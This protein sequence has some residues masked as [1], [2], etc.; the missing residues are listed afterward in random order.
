MAWFFTGRERA[1]VLCPNGLCGHVGRG[2]PPGAEGRAHVCRKCRQALP[3][4]SRNGAEPVV[5]MVV[6]THWCGK[7]SWLVRGIGRLSEGPYELEFP[8]EGQ[9][10]AWRALKGGLDCGRPVPATPAVPGAAWCIDFFKGK[11]GRRAYVHDTGGSDEGDA[12]VFMRYRILG[13]VDALVAV[14]D[15]FGIPAVWKKHGPAVKDMRPAV[16]PS[17]EAFGATQVSSL[18]QALE[19]LRKGRRRE[20]WEIPVA[21]VLTKLDVLGLGRS[22]GDCATATVES[23][24]L[25]CRKQLE[26]WGYG[27]LER[28]LEARFCRSV[29]F[30]CQPT[31]AGAFS[32]DAPLVWAVE[33]AESIRER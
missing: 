32:A 15:P 3:R 20:R 8:I 27:N 12:A 16:R 10:E 31:G 6:G 1:K 28:L 7:T 25:A 17:R 30:A 18:L 4:G 21:V 24:D 33:E 26:Q 29:F 13:R 19:T 11:A 22:F 23:V 5:V 9:A 14:V 2:A